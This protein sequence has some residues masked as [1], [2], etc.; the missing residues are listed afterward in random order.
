REIVAGYWLLQ[1]RSMDEAI[2]WAKRVPVEV[3]EH[4]Y[5]QESEIEIRQVFDLEEFGEGPEVDRAGGLEE[6]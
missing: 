3:A 2:E 1:V 6:E 4:D 5:G